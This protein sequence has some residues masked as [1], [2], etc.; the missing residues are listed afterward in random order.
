MFTSCSHLVHHGNQAS[1]NFS[2]SDASTANFVTWFPDVGVNQHVT[3]DIVGM[4][5]VEPYLDNDQLRV[6]DGK[7]LVISNTTYNI[8]HTPK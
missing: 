8:L 3:L 2:F 1:A 6:G 7:G 4:T 5:H